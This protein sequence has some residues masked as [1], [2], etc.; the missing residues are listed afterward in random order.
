[1][2]HDPDP[3]F[4]DLLRKDA[5]PERDP[6]FRVE[7]LCRLERAKYRRRLCA[8]L[9][10]GL[11]LAA[12][13]AVGVGIGGAAREATGVLL[14]GAALAAAYFIVAPALTQLLARLRT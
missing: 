9:A 7:V 14:I 11:V 1:M 13:A 6:V 2:T 4:A 3:R 8:L 10:L 12:I 5:P